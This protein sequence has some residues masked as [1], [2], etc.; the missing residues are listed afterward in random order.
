MEW[1]YHLV[2][3]ET[4]I[5]LLKAHNREIIYRTIECLDIFSDGALT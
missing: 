3:H 2:E 5:Y 4:E 1:N